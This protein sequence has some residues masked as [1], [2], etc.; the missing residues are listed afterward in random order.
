M[1]Y[2]T[3]SQEAAESAKAMVGSF[4]EMKS[5]L[6]TNKAIALLDDRLPDVL[7]WNDRLSLPLDVENPLTDEEKKSEDYMEAKVAEPAWF[8]S[9]WLLTE[10]Y[11]YRRIASVFAKR[12]LLFLLLF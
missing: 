6:Q 7:A 4:S 10:C 1:Y 5:Q 3:L 2:C 9:S 12:L 11:F 8:N